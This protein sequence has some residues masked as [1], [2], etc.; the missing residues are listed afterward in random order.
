M[1]RYRISAVDLGARLNLNLASEDELRR[2]CL[3]LGVDARTSDV[4][5]Q[6]IA[7]WRDDDDLHRPRGA[8]RA[9]Y[10]DEAGAVLPANAPFAEWTELRHVRGVTDDILQRVQPHLTVRGSGRV[11]LNAASRPVLLA[12]GL[13]A[14]AVETIELRQRAR[15]PIRSLEELAN[16]LSAAARARVVAEMPRLLVRTAFET[17]EIEVTSDGSVEGSPVGATS[18]AVFARAATEA[19]PVWRADR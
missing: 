10:V 1:Q 18:I 11:N 2:L 19:I 12:L 15:R 16:G 9:F 6:S 5:A 17:R 8:E 3:A 14:E 4:V 13:P 7:D